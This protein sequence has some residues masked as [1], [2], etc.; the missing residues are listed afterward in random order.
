MTEKRRLDRID[1]RIV[2]LLT[3]DSRITNQE[4]A[5]RVGVAPSTSLERVRRLR[6]EGVIR[7]AHADVDPEAL[8]VGLEALVA[9]RMRQHTR[10]LVEGFQAYAAAL[11]EVV[12]IFHLT[13]MEDFLV[14]V[15]CRDPHHLRQFSLDAFTTREEVAQIHTSLVYEH[16]RHFSWPDYLG[17]EDGN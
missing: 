15:A 5:S 6:E 7:G 14:H 3:E 2:A 13:G 11:P 16:H 9:V 8:G 1:R 17:D 4:L 12:Q 10:E